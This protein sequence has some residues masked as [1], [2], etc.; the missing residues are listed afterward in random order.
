MH[1]A[2]RYSL[3]PTLCMRCL[4]VQHATLALKR[5]VACNICEAF[6]PREKEAYLERATRASSASSMAGPSVA[7]GAPEPLLHDL[8]QDPLLDIPDHSPSPRSRRGSSGGM[9][10]GI[11]AGAR[12]HAIAASGEEASFSS[13]MQVGETPAEEEPGIEVASEASASLL[14]SR[15]LGRQRQNH[16]GPCSGRRRWLLALRSSWPSQTSWRTYSPPGI[17]QPQILVC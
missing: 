13:D 4:V 6:V 7:L 9:G 12:G 17:V 5:D 10:R 8:S 15:S 3:H 11:S 16:A 2:A 14:S 1:S